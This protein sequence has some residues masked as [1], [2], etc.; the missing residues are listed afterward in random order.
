MYPSPLR[1]YLVNPSLDKF[2]LLSVDLVLSGDM[3]PA[4][5]GACGTRRTGLP[6]CSV[7]ASSWI[8]CTTS[9]DSPV[10]SPASFKNS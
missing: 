4:I 8:E 5:A 10:P 6:S 9:T 2:S 1:S 7:S 3:V